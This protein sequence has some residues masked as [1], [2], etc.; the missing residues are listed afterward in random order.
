MAAFNGFLVRVQLVRRE[1]ITLTAL[2]GH[3]HSAQFDVER[4]L[5]SGVA[6]DV[7]GGDAGSSGVGF[8]THLKCSGRTGGHSRINRRCHNEVARIGTSFSDNQ[9]IQIGCS[10][11]YDRKGLGCAFIAHRHRAEAPLASARHDSAASRLLHAD[12]GMSGDSLRGIPMP[13]RGGKP[14]TA[15]KEIHL[16]RRGATCEYVN[17]HYWR[18]RTEKIRSGQVTATVE[19]FVW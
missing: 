4:V 9:I 17:I 14:N 1:K 10:G 11:V 6:C 18:C 16:E 15:L 5:A 3:A 19:S 7:K 8:E 2:R 13:S 12:I